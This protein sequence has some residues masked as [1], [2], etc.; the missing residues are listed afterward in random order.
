MSQQQ[1]WSSLVLSS[2]EA[3]GGKQ[4]A[5]ICEQKNYFCWLL[6][7]L[8]LLLALKGY[9]IQII[10]ALLIT[11]ECCMLDLALSCTQHF[12]CAE[13]KGAVLTDLRKV[14]I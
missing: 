4:A 8:S 10:H 13:A 2:L 6:A 9:C 14:R 1:T 3:T 11:L 12:S 7:L 5:L